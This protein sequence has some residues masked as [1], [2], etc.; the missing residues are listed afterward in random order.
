MLQDSCKGG[1]VRTLETSKSW[2]FLTP[3]HV[4]KLKKPIRD[5]LQDLTSLRARHDNTLTEID[6]NRRLAPDTYLGALR[7]FERPGGV[8]GLHGPGQTIDWLVKMQR[9]SDSLMLDRI[10]AD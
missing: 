5:D 1:T 2:V 7:I 4:Y 6:L 9:L 10:I 8:L 3:E